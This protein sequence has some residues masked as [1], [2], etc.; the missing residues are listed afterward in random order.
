MAESHA[1]LG[2]ALQGLG[3]LDASIAAYRRALEFPVNAQSAPV[4]NSYGVSLAQR[5]RLRE[6]AA[7]FREALRLDPS[8]QDARNNLARVGGGR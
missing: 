1:S 4:R 8:L 2:A 5:G 6:A 3:Q 7:E